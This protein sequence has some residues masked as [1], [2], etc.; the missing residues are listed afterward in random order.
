MPWVCLDSIPFTPFDSQTKRAFIHSFN[1]YDPADPFPSSSSF[2]STASSTTHPARF[3]LVSPS[4][5]LYPIVRTH[6][7][8]SLRHHPLGPTPR[9]IRCQT[10]LLRRIPPLQPKRAALINRR[11]FVLLHSRQFNLRWPTACFFLRE[12]RGKSCHAADLAAPAIVVA[13]FE[14]WGRGRL[15]ARSCCGAPLA[16]PNV[17]EDEESDEEYADRNHAVADFC[18][19]RERA[20]R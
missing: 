3:R 2:S 15:F 4:R 6:T 8:S 12:R 1:H 9:H 16:V 11:I 17:E 13:F 7:P 5:R 10:V 19:C 14:A 18:L 20:F